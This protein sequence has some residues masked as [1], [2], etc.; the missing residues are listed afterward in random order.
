[1]I[2]R[3][4]RGEVPPKHHIVFRSPEGALLH[5]ECLTR[6]GFDGHYSLLYHQNEPHR[7]THWER[8]AYGWP[9]AV[10]HD[11][12]TERP[13]TRRHYKSFELPAEGGAPIN[14]RVPILFNADVVVSILRPSEDDPTYL[15]NVDGDDLFYI[16]QGGGVL[17]SQFGDLRFGPRDYVCVPR[18]VKARFVLDADTP[19]YWVAFECRNE[20]FV[21]KQWRT[22]VGQLRMDAP[23]C[24]RDFRAPEFRGPVNEGIHGFTV[25]RMDRF[26]DYALPS[27]PLDVV[28]WDGAV[29]PWAFNILDFQPRAGLVH[30]PPDWHG[31][32]AFKGGIVCSFVPRVVD[33]HEQAIPCPYPHESVHCD[34]FLFY[35]EGNFVSRRGIESGSI[36]FHPAGIMHGPHPGAY[37]AS[38]GHKRTDELAVMMDTFAPLIPTRHARDIEDDE[39]HATWLP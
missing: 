13:L 26:T 15:A 18:G 16:H 3:L 6:N 35:A 9:A 38:I 14:A 4:C 24:H 32:F 11:D 21:P 8:S 27:S 2:E 7:H 17:R 36:S 10:A 33:F 12:E 30:L 29:Y 28:G 34:E 19:Q 31:T 23:Y 20:L 22:P 5:E 1:M 25:K 39:Y 37:E